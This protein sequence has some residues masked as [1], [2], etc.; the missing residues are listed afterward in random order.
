[1][2]HAQSYR[3]QTTN[4][5]R[6][7]RARLGQSG[8][9]A[10]LPVVPRRTRRGGRASKTSTTARPRTAV[11]GLSETRL[12]RAIKPCIQ[13]DSRHTRCVPN[14]DDYR[15]ACLTCISSRQECSRSQ[16]LKCEAARRAFIQH[17][18][19]CQDS[20]LRV[21]IGSA[22]LRESSN[23][24]AP[25]YKTAVSL[26]D[27]LLESSGKIIAPLIVLVHG[28]SDSLK[29][30]AFQMAFKIAFNPTQSLEAL[31][32]RYMLR[33][34]AVYICDG[35]RVPDTRRN[36]DEHEI[37]RKFGEVHSRTAQGNLVGLVNAWTALGTMSEPFS[38]FAM[39][40]S[41]FIGLEI[42]LPQAYPRTI[43]VSIEAMFNQLQ[44]PARGL[45]LDHEMLINSIESWRRLTHCSQHFPEI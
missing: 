20:I 12:T 24:P 40:L 30:N 2:V 45:K 25:I 8:P 41:L 21:Y 38:R 23:E 28:T 37:S 13:C 39:N 16:H 7:T 6:P 26:D 34:W 1:M 43:S 33:T 36:D 32:L 29:S 4:E 11:A 42:G 14:P 5:S 31:C 35:F 18:M 9:C 44:N 10:S 19:P 22:T 17:L 27:L 3:I 15:W